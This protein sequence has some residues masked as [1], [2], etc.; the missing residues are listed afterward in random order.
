MISPRLALAATA[1]TV[2]IAVPS[3]VAAASAT[4]APDKQSHP[5]ASTQRTRATA[6]AHCTHV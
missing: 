3:V 2:A 5:C 1:L 4:P 6:E